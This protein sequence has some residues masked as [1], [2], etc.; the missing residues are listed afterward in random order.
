V[1]GSH[2]EGERAGLGREPAD[3][4][5]RDTAA[6]PA[7]A[8]GPA[9]PRHAAAYA[10]PGRPTW[11][12]MPGLTAVSVVLLA[13]S[14]AG[15]TGAFP[16]AGGVSLSATPATAAAGVRE[17][18]ATWVASQVSRS[19]IVACDPAM[20]SVLHEQGVPAGD[21]LVLGTAASDPLGSDVVVATAAVRSEF[22]YSL[23]AVYAPV[24]LASFGSGGA[25]IDIRV[26]APDGAAA[27]RTALAQ[28][29]AARRQAGAQL[30]G[31]SRLSV[32][33]AARG[34][35]ADGM[36][37]S[38]LLITLAALA[39]LGPVRIVSFGAP[40]PGAS[41]GMPLCSVE[42]SDPAAA[43]AHHRQTARGASR[44]GAAYLRFVRAFLR[45]QR[46][47]YLAAVI[48]TVQLADGQPAIT[49]GFASPSPLGL[50]TNPR[51]ATQV[52]PPS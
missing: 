17:D 7:P 26:I 32:S 19:A 36:V 22:G 3:G 39:G 20:C 30:L 40:A 14:V 23:T 4:A 35:L 6:G 16:S 33:A 24:V 25:R 52:N 1:T 49:I 21:L 10:R 29:L 45:A 48:R 2:G 13:L 37:D 42:I 11:W 18:A 44:A 5:A 28:D 51:P 12:R 43:A 50:L 47:P 15:M 46:A 34:Q 9:A 27:Y 41:A 38:R 8:D 31:N